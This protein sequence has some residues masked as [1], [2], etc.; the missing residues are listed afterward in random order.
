MTRARNTADILSADQTILYEQEESVG[1]EVEVKRPAS[2]PSGGTN[3][4]IEAT[5]HV[6]KFTND[7]S[8]TTLNSVL[9]Y[10]DS[11]ARF[12]TPHLYLE[13]NLVDKTSDTMPRESSDITADHLD[14]GRWPTIQ[15][16]D[17][18]GVT[19]GAIFMREYRDDLPSDGFQIMQIKPNMA[20]SEASPENVTI[21]GEWSGNSEI[22][23]RCSAPEG[24]TGGDPVHGATQIWI[25]RP[26]FAAPPN[27]PDWPSVIEYQVW[28]EG[29]S[30]GPGQY[31]PRFRVTG[32]G[33]VQSPGYGNILSFRRYK[34]N[35]ETVENGLEL[36]NKLN[37]RHYFHKKKERWEYGF[38]IEELKD[39]FP[40]IVHVEEKDDQL[41]GCYEPDQIIPILAKAVQELTEKVAML[42]RKLEEKE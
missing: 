31:D 24:P 10:I 22:S 26:D 1:L 20:R 33:E 6:L 27:I 40:E 7:I 42:E 32:T 18:D 2:P 28:P 15:F 29:T 39:D 25:R 3:G 23:L 38:V 9:G 21:H 16:K 4:L 30:A 37:P 36:C 14:E 12:H 17:R 5:G 41:E 19:R 34:S 13:P 11:G 35:V 8:D